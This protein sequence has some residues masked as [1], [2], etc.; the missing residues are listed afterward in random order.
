MTSGTVEWVVETQNPNKEVVRLNV[1]D[2]DTYE[3]KK[4]NTIQAASVTGNADSDNHIN[5]TFSGT[6]AAINWNAASKADCTV[7]LWGE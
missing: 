4:F 5:I 6:A 3:S 2:G 7:V 1:N